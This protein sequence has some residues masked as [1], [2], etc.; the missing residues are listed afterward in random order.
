MTDL[1]GA[2]KTTSYQRMTPSRQLTF[3]VVILL[4]LLGIT[5]VFITF[6]S[7]KSVQEETD[8][9]VATESPKLSTEEG[10]GQAN[11]PLNIPDW[12]FALVSVFA[13]LQLISLLIAATKA[14]KRPL[15]LRDVKIISFLCETPMYIGLLGSLL[16]I[17]MNQFITGSLAA[18]LAYMTTITGIILFIFAKLTIWA[19]LPEKA[20]SYLS[21]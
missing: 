20:L 6:A 7:L 16:G 1:T 8:L 10:L 18:P 15:T 3:I 17:C 11:Q 12:L 13:A 21:E 14:K 2:A 9:V 5:A 4:L 19:T